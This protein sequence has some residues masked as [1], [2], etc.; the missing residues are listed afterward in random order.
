MK[1]DLEGRFHEKGC[2]LMRVFMAGKGSVEVL[3][4]Q[5]N[6]ARGDHRW[7]HLTLTLSLYLCGKRV[8]FLPITLEAHRIGTLLVCHGFLVTL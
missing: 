2:G 6:G 8:F 4:S 1:S 7:N 5:V 3:G